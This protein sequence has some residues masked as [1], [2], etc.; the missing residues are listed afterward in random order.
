[1]STTRRQRPRYQKGCVQRRTR[2]SHDVWIFRWRDESGQARCETLGTAL[3]LPTKKDALRKAAGRL[4]AI[5]SECPRPELTT[6]GAVIDR[7]ENE[8]MPRRHSTKSGYKPWLKNHV[9]PKWGDYLIQDVRTDAVEKWLANLALSG[10]SKGHIRS[11]MKIVFDCAVRWELIEKNPIW[12][13]GHHLVRVK[14]ISKRLEQP[15]VLTFDE[16]KR[17]L[18]KLHEPHRTMAT[19]AMCLGLRVSEILGLQWPDFDWDR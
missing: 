17:V 5:N 14:G 9:R 12:H 15:K 2:G 13:N 4:L 19:I 3:E 8:E 11:L 1:M 7:Y 10:K 6:F 16:C 18:E